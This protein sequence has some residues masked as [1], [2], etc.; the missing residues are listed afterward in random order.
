MACSRVYL[1]EFELAEA[2]G[3]E[4]LDGE[5]AED[6]AVDH[7]TSERRVI[8]T[9]AA[10]EVAHE[11]AGEGVARACRIMR[12]FKR[13]GRNTEDAAFVHH[14]GAVLAAFHDEGFGAELEDVSRGQKEVMFVG[15]LARFGI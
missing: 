4:F 2:L 6:G 12:L 11:A 1:F 13:E 3:A 15:E 10:G 9:A 7:C 5:A 8:R 14:H